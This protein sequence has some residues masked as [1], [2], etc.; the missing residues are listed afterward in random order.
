ML[1]RLIKHELF[2]TGRIMLPVLGAVCVGSVVGHFAMKLMDS[3]L[4]VALEIF[5]GLLIAAFY[6]A[7]VTACVMPFVVT[8]RRFRVNV[9][10]DEGYLTMTLPVS[11]HSV[12]VSKLIVSL[13]WSAVT[14]AAVA[15]SMLL[16]ATGVEFIHTIGEVAG[17]FYGLSGSAEYMDVSVMVWELAGVGLIGAVSG[18]LSFYA[19]MSVGYGAANHKAMLSVLVYFGLGMVMGY[20]N[21]TLM[22]I[23]L[24]ILRIT[25][26]AV[27][28]SFMPQWTLMMVL[29]AVGNIISAAIY[30]TITVL[31]LKY[32]LNLE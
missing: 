10:G 17:A 28:Q 21:G 16:M 14:V 29:A 4:P 24:S 15:V 9:L 12:I 23:G 5:L 26:T 8:V 32:R 1:G 19:A 13:M 22:N 18:V 31:N 25:S 6:L 27:D 7:L 30:Y 2:A 11:V 3:G 20:L